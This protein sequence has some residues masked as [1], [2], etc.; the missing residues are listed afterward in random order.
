VD[1]I[2]TIVAGL[3]RSGTSMMMKMLEAGGMSVLTDD[4]RTADVDNPKGYYEYERVKQIQEDVEWLQDARGRV[5]K[6]VS[7][8]LR[9][10]PGDYAYKVIFMKRSLHEI[11][12]SQHKMLVHRGE[13]AGKVDD[14]QMQAFFEQ[15]LAKVRRW[16]DAQP[17]IETLYVSYNDVLL[18]PSAHV[19]RVNAF[20]GGKLNESA[21]ARV[22]DP[23]LYRNR[24]SGEG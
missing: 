11:L 7:A 6:M 19:A 3:P 9:H 23:S 1:D 16:L 2:V 22:V 4:E 10:L 24:R 18:E 12:A 21:M 20:L 17:N 15:H 13:P 8:L 5:V 14:D